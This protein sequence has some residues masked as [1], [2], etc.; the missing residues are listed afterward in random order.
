MTAL[1]WEEPPEAKKP[2]RR[3]SK[4]SGI[5]A[6][7]LDHE[8]EWAKALEQ[9]APSNVTHAK[10]F[11]GIGFEVVGRNYSDDRKRCDVYV[12]YVGNGAS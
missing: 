8:G 1:V 12:R 5:V 11:L 10:H 7:L 3:E 2:D 6:E 4:W 9:A